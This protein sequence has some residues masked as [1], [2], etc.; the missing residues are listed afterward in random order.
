MLDTWWSTVS[1]KLSVFCSIHPFPIQPPP[2]VSYHPCS[3]SILIFSFSMPAAEREQGEQFHKFVS[4]MRLKWR[5]GRGILFQCALLF[6]FSP[7][8]PPEKFCWSGGRGKRDTCRIPRYFALKIGALAQKHTR[9]LKKGFRSLTLL[10]C[11]KGK[12]KTN[13]S[14]L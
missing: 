3:S 5:Q 10:V 12:V 7:L 11:F 1:K 9:K 14:N 4:Q 2:R 8:C 13:L 6:N